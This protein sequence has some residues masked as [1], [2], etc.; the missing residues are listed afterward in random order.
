M[1]APATAA[2][3]SPAWAAPADDDPPGY[4][5]SWS[6]SGHARRLLTLALTGLA[7]A[8]ITGRAEFAGLAAPAVLLLAAWRPGRPATVTVRSG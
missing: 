7:A 4:R 3:S 5:V 6:L 8:V 2:S 1:T